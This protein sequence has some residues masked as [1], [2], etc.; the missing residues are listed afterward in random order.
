[1]T[2]T[3]YMKARRLLARR[4]PVIGALIK[5]HGPCGL[6]EAQHEDTFTALVAGSLDADAFNGASATA[7][8]AEDRILYSGG[9]LYY[10]PDG[11]GGTAATL[12]ATLTGAPAITQADF[13]IVA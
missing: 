2:T 5:R 4:D 7:Q 10:D 8:D 3:D 12:F 9:N 13:L 1:M 11:I 6:A